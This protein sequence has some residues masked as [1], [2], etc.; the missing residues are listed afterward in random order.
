MRRLSIV[1]LVYAG[2]ALF[3]LFA[4]MPSDQDYKLGADSQPNETS[5]KGTVTKYRFSNSKI[6]PGTVRDYWVYVPAQYDSSK[7]ACL[8][9]FQDGGGYVNADGEW[10]VPVVMDNL[11]AEKAMPVTVGLFVDPGVIPGGVIPG[12]VI[13]IPGV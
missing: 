11:I 4:S 13:P 2:L 1:V 6:F 7:A 3:P 8:I 12:G 10:R 5:P 9:V